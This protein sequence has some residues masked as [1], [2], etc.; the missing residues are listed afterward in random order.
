[1]SEI[2]PKTSKKRVEPTN[3]AF[4]LARG[5]S[6]AN[7]DGH[8]VPGPWQLV[9]IKFDLESGQIGDVSVT[10]MEDLRYGFEK[11]QVE[12]ELEVITKESK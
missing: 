3:T 11:I 9:K 6:V 1:M 8:L 4:G 12:L 7:A 5:P 2:T 10:E